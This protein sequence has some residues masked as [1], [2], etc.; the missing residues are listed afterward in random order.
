MAKKYQRSKSDE[1]FASVEDPDKLAE[2]IVRKITEWRGFLTNKGLVSLWNKKLMNYYGFSANGNSSQAV[3]RGGSE[4]ELSLVKVNDLHNLI[5]NQL[6]IITAQRPSGVAR[7]INSNTESLRSARIGSAIAEYYQTQSNFEQKFVNTVETALLL[8]EA[9]TELF[10]DMSAGDPIAVDPET[11]KPVMS[12]DVVL[13]THCPWNVAR[14]PGAKV[15]DQKYSILSYRVNRF[16]AA[17]MYPDFKDEI[18]MAGEDALPKLALDYL[19]E[20]SDEIF[21]HRLVHDRT[22]AVPDGRYALM[23]A[24]KIVYDSELPYKDYPV[25]RVA[26]SD[27]IDGP[28]GYTSAND[29][30]GLE[31]VTDALHSIITTNEITF[32]GQT[33]IGA[34]GSDIKHTDLAKGV[35]YFEVQPEFVDKIK[36]LNLVRTAPEIFQYVNVLNN[37]KEQQVGVNSVVR[38]Q[39]EGALSGASGSALALIQSQAISFNSG[40]QR[41]Y[42]RLM[43]SVMSK[44][45]GILRSYADTP[46]VAAIVGKSKSMGLKQFKYTG[47]DLNAISS[48]VYEQTNPVSQSIGGRL[49]MAQDLI[50]ANMIKSPK[51]YITVLTTGNLDT[52]TEDD[53]ADQLLILE[54][55][56]FMSDGKPVKAVITEMHQDHIKSH[57]SVLSSVEAKQDPKITSLVLG[58]IQEHID[59]W[60]QASQSNPGLLFATGQQMIPMAPPP[61]QGPP[62]GAPPQGGPPPSGPAAMQNPQSGVQK[63]AQDVRQPSLPTVAGTNQKAQVPGVTTNPM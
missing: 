4:G 48:I 35:R 9:Y 62:P 31:Q 59:L 27:V 51:Q 20:G 54:E 39:P 28:I 12:G 61:P 21:V 5:Q 3:Q 50:K 7:A 25:D 6:V 33:I 60:T 15:E 63:K 30:M 55:N 58:H 13:R 10:W 38:G 47:K 22:P 18:M 8:D 26:P 52:M 45:I 34:I 37:K 40:T 1:Y 57:M 49:Q 17:T 23:I 19:P 32:G 14:D 29:I 42:F 16:D 11:G 43:S 36:P 44:T 2:G 46:R 41:G 53:E 24:E 56:E